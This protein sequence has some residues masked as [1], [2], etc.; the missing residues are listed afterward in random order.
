MGKLENAST[1]TSRHGSRITKMLTWLG[2][3][4]GATTGKVVIAVQHVPLFRDDDFPKNNAYW[5]VNAPYAQREVDL[6]HKLGVKH[7][8]AGHWHIGRVF[9]KDG[10]TI[11]VAPATRWLPMGGKLGFAMHIITPEGDVHTEFV[12]LPNATP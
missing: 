5:I 1:F 2:Q 3:Q 10:I 8:L 12:P 9:E 7:L 11:Q 4:A 6:L